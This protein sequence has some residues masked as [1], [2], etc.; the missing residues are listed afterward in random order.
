MARGRSRSGT[1]VTHS[2]HCSLL[3]SPLL[4]QASMARYTELKAALEEL[5]ASGQAGSLGG[6]EVGVASERIAARLCVHLS[7]TL[8]ANPCVLT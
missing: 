6:S 4:L 7:R 5:E 8:H 3:A 1:L 2:N